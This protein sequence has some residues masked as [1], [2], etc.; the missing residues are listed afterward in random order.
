M[1]GGCHCGN[2]SVEVARAPEFINLCDCSLCRKSGGAWGYYPKA[3]VTVS[4]VPTDYRRADA[5][6]DEQFVEMHFCSSCGTTTHWTL[7]ENAEGDRLGVN[8]RIFDPAELE[9][10]EV[11]TID[12]LHWDGSAPPQ[13]RRPPGAF[14]RDIFL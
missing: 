9:G 7:T 4:G 6:A 13:H 11:R 1:K 10:V 3:E 12:G 5:D 8:I 14:G 2:V